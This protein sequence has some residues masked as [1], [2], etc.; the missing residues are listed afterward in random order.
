M[1]NLSYVRQAKMREDK[2]KRA[3]RSVPA[4]IKPTLGIK[5]KRGGSGLTVLNERLP[6]VCA[7]RVIQ[8]GPKVKDGCKSANLGWLETTA[9]RSPQ[10]LA[11]GE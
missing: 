8:Y 11:I 1:L 2:P 9:A 3:T 6:A 4:Q 10:I 7:A 5:N